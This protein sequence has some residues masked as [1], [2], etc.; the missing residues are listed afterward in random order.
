MAE[1]PLVKRLCYPCDHYRSERFRVQGD[2]GADM[3]CDHPDA[4]VPGYMGSY[5]EPR[6]PDWCPVVS[7]KRDKQ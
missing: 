2:T 3:H 5:G 1:G 4:P 7:P 6:T